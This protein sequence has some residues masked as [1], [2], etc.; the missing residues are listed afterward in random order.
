MLRDVAWRDVGTRV[1]VVI[2]AMR[3]AIAFALACLTGCAPL[4]GLDEPVISEDDTPEP[5]VDAGVTRGCPTKYTI[6]LPSSTTRYRVLEAN[7][8]FA[9]QEAACRQDPPGAGRLVALESASE[10]QYLREL[11][12]QYEQ[13]RYYVG[14][15]QSSNQA[16]PEEGWK[17]ATGG[18]VPDEL[19]ALDQPIDGP[20]SHYVEDNEANVAE[21]GL[22]SGM[23]FDASGKALQPAICECDP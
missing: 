10:A 21:L 14:A 16:R 2:C 15:A 12:G 1:A 17:L 20:S 3:C 23:L 11:L 5:A 6:M 8:M 4:F 7:A 19:W 13:A 22:E 18:P 9:E